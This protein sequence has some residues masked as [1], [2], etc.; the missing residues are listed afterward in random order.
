MSTHPDIE[1]VIFDEETILK[2]VKEMGAQIAADYKD[3][4]PLLLVVLRGSF[5]FAS[6]MEF[7]FSFPAHPFPLLAP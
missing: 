2:R 5:M 6:K 1:R 3:L 4:K 7:Q